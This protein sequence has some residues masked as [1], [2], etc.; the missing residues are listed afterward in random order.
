MKTEYK[1]GKIV[2]NGRLFEDANYDVANNSVTVTFNGQGFISKYAV[3]KEKVY[4]DSPLAMVKFVIG[5]NVIDVNA[6]KKVEMI[7][8]TQ[9][10]TITDEK[11]VVTVKCFIDK[12]EACVF[13][14]VNIKLKEPLRVYFGIFLPFASCTDY[15]KQCES[16][17]FVEKNGFSFCSTT[18]FA[19]IPENQ[20]ILFD[21]ENKTDI[22]LDL[23]YAFHNADV[24]ELCVDIDKYEKSANDEIKIIKLPDS[25]KTERDHA[26]YYN[27][28]FCALQ[29]YKEVDSFKGFTAGCRYIAPIRTY[30]RDS[31]FT[32]LPMYNGETEKIRNQIITLAKGI[33]ED[34]TCP[35]AVKFDCTPFWGEHYDSP[36]FFCIS[37]YDYVNN[38]GDFSLLTEKIGQ[39]TILE[40]A[41]KV[42]LKL[43][44]NCDETGLIIKPGKYNQRDWAD[45][46]NRYGYVTYDEILYARALYCISKLFLQNDNEKSRVYKNMHFRVKDAVN[47]LLWDESLGYY[48]NFKN[49]DYTENNLSVDTVLSVIFDIAEGERAERFLDSCEKLLESRNHTDLEDFGVMCVYPTYSNI[50]SARNKSARPYDYHNGADWPYWSAMYAYALKLKYREFEYPLTKWFDFNV[51]KGNF[52]PIEYYSPYCKD[53]SLLQAWS[54]AAAFVYNDINCDF[55]KNKL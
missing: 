51:Q 44:E 11:A 55:F 16:S 36:S 8:R 18:A 46:V 30:Y 22:N 45:E 54:A 53:G 14:R 15:E 5:G 12:N 42:L 17:T 48:V 23:V 26:L 31:Y 28:Y 6:E 13:E 19:Y 10:I 38:T 34:G 2:A 9:K 40:L 47:S 1:D 39:Y 27:A 4:F 43:S 32:V 21:F 20:E 33:S 7:G 24:K 52:T 25:V 50:E 3:L 41:E 49:E 35:S 29:N 37:L